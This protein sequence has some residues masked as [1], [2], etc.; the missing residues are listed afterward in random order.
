VFHFYS[1]SGR[2][3]RYGARLRLRLAPLYSDEGPPIRHGGDGALAR[4]GCASYFKS[5]PIPNRMGSNACR[6]CGA[7]LAVR[8]RFFCDRCLTDRRDEALQAAIPAFKAARP[9]KIAAMRATGYDPSTTPE[10]QHR[11]AATASQQRKAAVAWRDDGSLDGVDFRR[12]ILPKLQRLPVRAIA[13]AMDASL[14]HG[15]KVRGGKL[16]PHKRHWPALALLGMTTK[17]QMV[18]ESH[19]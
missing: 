14:S 6:N 17:D 2:L 16:V 9:A 15:S 12:D 18:L 5:L 4:G 3:A 19:P 7:K 8:K 11:R 10:A 13:E 1:A